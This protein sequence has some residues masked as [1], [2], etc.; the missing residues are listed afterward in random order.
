M[1][2]SVVSD[3]FI[4]FVAAIGN[5][6]ILPDPF[7]VTFDIMERSVCTVVNTVDDEAL[8]GD[9]YFVVSLGSITPSN[10]V[11]GTPA[12]VIISLLDNDGKII[13]YFNLGISITNTPSLQSAP[14]AT[15]AVSNLVQ[16]I[17]EGEGEVQ[18]CVEIVELP[19]E[20]LETDL[21]VFLEAVDNPPKAGK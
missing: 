3:I 12:S 18:I 7:N 4:V 14:N 21:I 6:Y 15:V 8:E 10:V 17:G 19:R 9:H 11:A 1:T 20:G 2:Q 16:E 5:D 13:L